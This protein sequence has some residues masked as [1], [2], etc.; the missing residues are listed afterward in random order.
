MCSEVRVCEH[1]TNIF[2]NEESENGQMFT[3]YSVFRTK[4]VVHLQLSILWTLCVCGS[5]AG[6]WKKNIYMIFI[7]SIATTISVKQTSTN[8]KGTLTVA[9]LKTLAVRASSA[10]DIE[11]YISFHP[12]SIHTR[13]PQLRSRE[14]EIE[15]KHAARL[16]VARNCKCVVNFDLTKTHSIETRFVFP[17]APCFLCLFILIN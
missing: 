17:L 9:L 14:R 6:W 11:Q 8:K 5:R 4:Q 3:I 15:K 1:R 7:K 16:C 10:R 13:V 12:N 2:V